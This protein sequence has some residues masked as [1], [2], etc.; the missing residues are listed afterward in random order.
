MAD[1]TERLE[2]AEMNNKRPLVCI[3]ATEHRED[4][5]NRTRFLKRST[6]RTEYIMDKNRS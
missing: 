3:H 6:A 2:K 1:Q 5:R 4:L